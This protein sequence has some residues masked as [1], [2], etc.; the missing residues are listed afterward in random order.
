[1]SEEEDQAAAE[2]KARAKLNKDLDD[3][4][5]EERHELEAMPPRGDLRE[6][7]DVFL[8]VQ[9]ETERAGGGGVWVGSNKRFSCFV[10]RVA[11]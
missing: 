3:W 5:A 1:M 11:W 7:L 9:V 2:A 6:L 8:K 10:H 4:A